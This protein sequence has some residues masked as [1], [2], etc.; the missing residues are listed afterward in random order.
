VFLVLIVITNRHLCKYDFLTHINQIAK[1]KPNKI[2][3]RENDLNDFEYIKLAKKVIAICNRYSTDLAIHTHIKTAKLLG[4]TS[5]HL[6]FEIFMENMDILNDFQSI[7]VSIHSKKEGIIAEEFGATY[8]LAG[9]IFPT[10]SKK[11]L[12]HRTLSFLQELNNISIDVYGLGGINLKRVGSVIDAGAD[13]IGVMS[14]LMES[15]TPYE[16]TIKYNQLLDEKIN[17]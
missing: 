7:G 9:H 4:I 10:K 16:T 5:I 17:K 2:I 1:A 3:L 13:G 15:P 6:P 11:G 8:I 14:S 12:K